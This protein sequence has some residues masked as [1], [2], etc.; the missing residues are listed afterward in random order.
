MGVM[1]VRH[2]YLNIFI[3]YFYKLG[4]DLK[5][6]YLSFRWCKYIAKIRNFSMFY[7]FQNLRDP[8]K[9]GKFCA[10][11]MGCCWFDMDI[12]IYTHQIF[13]NLVSVWRGVIH[14]FGNVKKMQKFG[15]LYEY[16]L[17][18]FAGSFLIVSE[19]QS[20]FITKIFNQMKHETSKLYTQFY[21][22]VFI[23]GLVLQTV[24]IQIRRYCRCW[25]EF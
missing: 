4:N 6:S 13:I 7:V 14:L 11:R 12:S 5:R 9:F 22:I 18:K 8:R 15:T 10:V 23:I 1:L 19:S 2:N 25:A 17:S 16:L 21:V 3:S 20:Q 24:W